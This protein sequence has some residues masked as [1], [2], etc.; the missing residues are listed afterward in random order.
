MGSDFYEE[1]AGANGFPVGRLGVA[2]V[3]EP[4]PEAFE[5]AFDRGV[6]YFWGSRRTA[7]MGE[8]IRRIVRKGRREDMVLVLQSYSR[9][10]GLMRTL[11]RRGLRELRAWTRQTCCCWAG[12]TRSL[13]GF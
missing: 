2:A 4:Q 6:N 7:A 10:A 8:A 11:F 5:E 9:H 13:A 3:T 12:T 1:G